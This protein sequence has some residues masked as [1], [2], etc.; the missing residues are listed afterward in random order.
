[1]RDRL[2]RHALLD[3]YRDWLPR[4]RFP[5][6][7]LELELP[8][9]AVDVN[10]HPAKWEVRFAEPQRVH[11]LV[12]AAVR[13]AV[14][15]R[16]WLA[17]PGRGAPAPAPEGGGWPAFGRDAAPLLATSSGTPR[18][19]GTDW[20]FA[21]AP[22]A[23]ETEAPSA[24]ETEA[25][26]TRP[27]PG[28]RFADLRSVGQLL[29]TYLV[30]EDKGGLL[31]VDQHAAHERVLYE[32]MRRAW[33]EGGVERQ[34]LLVPATIELDEASRAA[35]EAAGAGLEGLGFEVESFGP[36]AV[37][38]RAMPALLAGRDPAALVR[39]LADELRSGALEG[40]AV[41]AL[42]GGTSVRLL[43]AADRLF[44]SLACHAARR[45]GDVLAPGEQRA[46]LDS[47]DGIPWAPTCPHGR[48]VAVPISLAE[49]ERRF[50]R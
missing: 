37:L 5:T 13:R 3:A 28:P 26:A 47:L 23:G 18:P 48:P 38:V 49:I 16:G 34:A 43:E 8:A 30:L 10:V 45:A 41:P 21:E 33:L 25:A 31:L 14:E 12:S 22:A 7:L 50:G 20:I 35:L 4:G 2:L 19:A 46:L 42:G 29:G 1:V 9:D 17:Q 40:G 32:R 44:A 36:G 39:G 27:A 11:A 6:A 15:A 24:R